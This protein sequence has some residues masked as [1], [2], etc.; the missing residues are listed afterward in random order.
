M[1]MVEA[2]SLERISQRLVLATDGYGDHT[3]LL[4]PQD[5]CKWFI[6]P[7]GQGSINTDDQQK[8]KN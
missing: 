2:P 1:L 8:L 6:T 4:L 7:Y 3:G 5:N